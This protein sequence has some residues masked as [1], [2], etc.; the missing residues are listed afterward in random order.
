MS[1]VITAIQGVCLTQ[2]MPDTG[3]FG[4]QVCM[5]GINLAKRPEAD[6]SPMFYGQENPGKCCPCG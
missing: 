5:V 3:D 6:D 2:S 1:K 4:D